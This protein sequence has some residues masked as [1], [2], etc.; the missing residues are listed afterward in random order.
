MSKD[1]FKGLLKWPSSSTVNKTQTVS[2][3]EDYHY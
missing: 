3:K 2:Q 1:I